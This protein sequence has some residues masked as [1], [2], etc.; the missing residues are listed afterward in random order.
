MKI[1]PSDDLSH[2]PDYNRN[3]KKYFK[4]ELVDYSNTQSTKGLLIPSLKNFL[5]Q[6]NKISVR[7]ILF[8][9]S[10]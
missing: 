7:F 10:D 3:Y 2:K 5:Q 9:D 6:S 1:L 4:E 8:K